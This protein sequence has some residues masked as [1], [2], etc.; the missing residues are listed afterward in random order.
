ML[1]DKW[2]NT[3]F[4]D[5]RQHDAQ[6]FCSAL[7]DAV[8]EDCNSSS[9]DDPEWKAQEVVCRKRVEGHRKRV[10]V[11]CTLLITVCCYVADATVE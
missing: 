8:H 1:L 10:R 9:S 4:G 3:Q 7:L 6:E 2:T 5:K 11:R